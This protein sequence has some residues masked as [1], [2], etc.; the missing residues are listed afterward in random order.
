MGSRGLL[1]NS[2]RYEKSTLAVEITAALRTLENCAYRFHPRIKVFFGEES[3]GV[4]TIG[5]LGAV[6]RTA[7]QTETT[8][9]ASAIR[10][11]T[12]IDFTTGESSTTIHEWETWACCMPRIATSLTHL[13]SLVGGPYLS[14]SCSFNEEFSLMCRK[15]PFPSLLCLFYKLKHDKQ[16]QNK[17]IR[18]FQVTHF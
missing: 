5:S 7:L 9:V 13:S 4:I 18:L 17:T 14:S 6:R 11:D 1:E 2:S 12:S 16:Q 10:T 3:F 8:Y 15:T